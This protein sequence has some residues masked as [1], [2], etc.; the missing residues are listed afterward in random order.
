MSVNARLGLIWWESLTVDEQLAML[1]RARAFLRHPASGADCWAL[2]RAGQ[3]KMG[4]GVGSTPVSPDTEVPG[5][6]L[7]SFSDRVPVGRDMPREGDRAEAFLRGP[8]PSTAIR[9]ARE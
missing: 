4:A 9:E 3:I 1:R 7:V 5:V 2:W 8:T 6:A